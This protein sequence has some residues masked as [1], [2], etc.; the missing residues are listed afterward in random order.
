MNYYI[1]SDAAKLG[2]I[3][4]YTHKDVVCFRKTIDTK[5][6]LV[7]VNIRNDQVDYA[8]P[9]DLKDSQWM[10]ALNHDEVLLESS[11]QLDNYQYFL[12]EN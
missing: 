2:S 9:D 12:M 8:L 5:E 7:I 11:L 1:Q 10:D 6:L 4:Y 3:I